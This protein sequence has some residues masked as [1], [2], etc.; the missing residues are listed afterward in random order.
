MQMHR[1]AEIMYFSRLIMG[2]R[3]SWGKAAGDLSSCSSEALG[4]VNIFVTCKFNF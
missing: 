2:L 1:K 3:T 4:G